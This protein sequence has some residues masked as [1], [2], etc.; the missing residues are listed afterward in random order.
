MTKTE[1]LEQVTKLLTDHKIKPDAPLFKELTKMFE[2]KT[3]TH[4]VE[5]PP[6]VDKE[7]NIAEI[8]CAWFKEYRPAEGFNKSTKSKT[9]YHYECK[10]AETEWKKYG[11]EIK[12]LKLAIAV[13]TDE[14]LDEKITIDEGKKKRLELNKQIEVLEANR[15]AKI[16]FDDQK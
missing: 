3:R 15:L 8:Y 14:I 12:N 6:K 7:G 13:L 2:P 4:S 16:N 1:T 11:K 5:F 10:D 9:G